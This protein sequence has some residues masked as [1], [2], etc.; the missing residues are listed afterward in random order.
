[1]WRGLLAI[2]CGL[3]LVSPAKAEW[4]EARSRH[5]ILYMN[6][7]EKEIR[8]RAI[9]LERM[10][11]GLRKFT[12][13]GEGPETNSSK[14]SVFV[15]S[16]SNIRSLCDCR[17]AAGFYIATYGGSRAFVG[18]SAGLSEFNGGKIILFHEYAHH[19]LL[20]NFSSAFPKWYSE[21]FAE[22]A[23]TMRIEDD[24]ATIGVAANHRASTMYYDVKLDAE[25]LLDT[26]SKAY[27]SKGSASALYARGWLMTHYMTFDKVR[28]PQFNA[29]IRLINNGA[30]S[31]DAAREAFGDLSVLNRDLRAYLGRSTIPV[32]RMAYADAPVPKVD[33]RRLTDPEEAMFQYRIRSVKGVSRAEGQR[34]Y[35][36]AAPTAAKYPKDAVVQGWL[37][38]MAYDAGEDSAAEEAATRTIALDPRALQ[39]HLYLGMAKLR[40][41][42]EAKSTR[43]ADWAA[44][45]APIVAAN[46]IDPDDAR[47]LWE[48]WDSF[49]LEGR[50]PP[51]S[52][53]AGLYRAQELAPQDT[54]VRYAAAQARIRAGEIDVGKKLLRPIAYHPHMPVDNFASRIID[55]LDAG[56]PVEEALAAGGTAEAQEEPE[57]EASDEK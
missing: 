46:R 17:N 15:V 53:F 11:W 22:F 20:G 55:A 24:V 30:P 21:G 49:R 43:P 14:L 36:S 4:L 33:V 54:R 37:A 18:E 19:F 47:P 12:Q 51:P 42:E 39:G 41:L 38:E 27:T 31:L 13:V 1:M 26:S 3:M 28:A 32:T 6:G 25:D 8:R 10:D 7:S 50:A 34:V 56:K 48:F 23:S 2:I 29:Y 35:R 9:E 16:E 44:A 45:R 40:K 5:F 52:A 57:S